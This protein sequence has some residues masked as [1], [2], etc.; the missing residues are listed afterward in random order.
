MNKTVDIIADKSIAEIVA[1]HDPESSF[2]ASN[3]T[4]SVGRVVTGALVIIAHETASEE[5][6]LESLKSANATHDGP[7]IVLSH[8]WQVMS[9]DELRA[10][11]DQLETEQSK[12]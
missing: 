12:A 1:E 5:Q 3:M 10:E 4:L 2:D 9:G 8:D 7:V 11:L 6:T